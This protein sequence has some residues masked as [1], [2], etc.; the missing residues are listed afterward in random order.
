MS[1]AVMS[2]VLDESEARLGARL[3]LLALAD[4][5]HDD[6][7]KA[8]PSVETL[9]RKSKLSERGTRDA[10]RKLEA[11]GMVVST[12]KTKYGTIIY[13]VV[14]PF[15][16]QGGQNLPGGNSQHEGGQISA[17]ELSDSA[18]DPSVE[19]SRT[20][21]SVDAVRIA[22]LEAPGLIQHRDA[23]FAD[24]AMSRSIGKAVAKYGQDDVVRAIQSYA[25]VLGSP[26]HRWSHSWT[27]GDFLRRG[28]D[29]FVPEAKPEDVFLDRGR[30]RKLSSGDRKP[31]RKY[32][33]PINA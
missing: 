15:N 12:G 29:R 17:L 22:W 4:Y 13:T 33:R 10:L 6:G 25:F 18:P 19:P 14:G 2:W 9:A 27:L 24:P 5:A 31:P 3:V 1:L 32:T 23:Y 20:L 11:D 21:P 8:F 7:S 16:E 30:P 26:D 28:L